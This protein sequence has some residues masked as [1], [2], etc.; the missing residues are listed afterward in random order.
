LA[1]WT[2]S[3]GGGGRGLLALLTL[4][5][6]ARFTLLAARRLVLLLALLVA[7][8]GHFGAI[9]Q[10]EEDDRRRIPAP[11]AGLDDPG[12]AAVALGEARGD[13]V[14]DPSDALV[15]GAGR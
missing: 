8:L 13:G 3:L 5:A 9:D 6:G 2:A 1:G 12:V 4:A 7:V 15:V 14:E 10:L 11:H